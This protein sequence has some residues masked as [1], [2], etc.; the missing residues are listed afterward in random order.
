MLHQVHLS[1]GSNIEPETYL[2]RALELLKAHGT[3]FQSSTVWETEPVGSDG[4]NYLNAC[5]L[6][7]TPLNVEE[8]RDQVIHPIEARLGRHRTDDKFAPRTIDIDIV[9]FDDQ[10]CDDRYWDLAYVV[11][12]LAE[13]YPD[14]K[15]PLTGE[16]VRETAARLRPGVWMEARPD[17]L[18]QI[19]E[20]DFNT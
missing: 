5:I 4:P 6:F 13:I 19:N 3:I 7:S 8:L 10:S 9:L 20:D 14:F 2:P 17:L 15:N 12:P 16:K 1:L 18:R 11:I